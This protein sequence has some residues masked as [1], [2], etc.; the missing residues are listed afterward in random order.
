[1]LEKFKK[2]YQA[3]VNNMAAAEGIIK[4][5]K[6]KIPSLL[7]DIWKTTGFGKYNKLL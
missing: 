6:E 2:H 3:E 1:M 7:I 5:Y 4:E